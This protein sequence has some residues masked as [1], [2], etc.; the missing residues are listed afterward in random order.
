LRNMVLCFVS[1]RILS[2]FMC[3]STNA[4]M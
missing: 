2:P 4:L 1:L 3:I